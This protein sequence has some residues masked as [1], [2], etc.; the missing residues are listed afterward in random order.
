MSA[1]SSPFLA[2]RL[3]SRL[4]SLRRANLERRLLNHVEDAERGCNAAGILTHKG[5]TPHVERCTKALGRACA[6][7]TNLEASRD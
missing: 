2:E 7:I 4:S 3:I 1:S 6:I 5:P